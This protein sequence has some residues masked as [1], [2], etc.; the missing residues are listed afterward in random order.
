MRPIVSYG[1][2]L[3]VLAAAGTLLFAVPSV[4]HSMN[5]ARAQ[6]QVAIA[7]ASIQADDILERI[8]AA[9]RAVADSVEP[10]VVHLQVSTRGRGRWGS[11]G[12][13]WVFD[14]AGH[15]V[16][17]AHVV[18][19]ATRVAVQ[20]QD[21]RV[22]R[23]E[24]VS[25]D[26]LTDIAVIKVET[27]DHIVPAIRATG[28]RLHQG[29]RVYAFGS[30]F[31]FKF[32]M[33]EGIVSGLGRSARS[34]FGFSQNIS[35]YIQTDAAVNPGNS[36]GPLVNVHGKVV[37]MNVA[38]ATA[39]DNEGGSQGQSAGISFA[40]PLATI[41][42]RVS[43]M[44]GGGE[45][46]TGFMGITFRNSEE[47]VY[48]AKGK[49][50]GL[51]V[52]IGGINQGGPADSA[53]LRPGD[54]IVAIDGEETS[55]SDVMR[56]I[57]S[58]K[59]PGSRVPIRVYRDGLPMEFEVTLG[60]ISDDARAQN[61]SGLLFEQYRF[62]VNERDGRVVVVETLPLS[63]DQSNPFARNEVITAVGDQPVS[64]VQ[65]FLFALER[66]G[67]FLGR[68]VQVRV[69]YKDENGHTLQRDVT[70]RQAR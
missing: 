5:A 23:G 39:D 19:D 52:E 9:T 21:G 47:P 3:V 14:D 49:H 65:E 41:E 38:I 51:G 33:S 58:S 43:Q 16:T 2:G 40:I 11:T 57:I 13:G 30:P 56:A 61:F 66:A 53:G 54:M 20:F 62:T 28:E 35:N 70:L 17:N 50:V 7:R 10:S 34:G 29:E 1:P 68:R 15:I 42:S 18:G 46:R 36:G 22:E 69:E 55:S 45:L 37:G 12:S 6:Q 25:A 32:S 8:N 48:D 24:V 60:T 26:V 31:G 67:A 63:M 27:G 59:A 4:M 44:I 64:T